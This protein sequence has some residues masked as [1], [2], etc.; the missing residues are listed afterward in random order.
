MF[1]LSVL[2]IVSLTIG[3]IC[4]IYLIRVKD[5]TFVS[6]DFIW[7]IGIYTGSSPFDLQGPDNVSN[8]VLTAKD[9]TD[10]RAGFV[11]DPFIVKEGGRWYMF[12]EVW[13]T[14][15][16]RAAIAYASS[17]DG[18]R[19]KYEQ[20][21]LKEPFHLSYPC[22]FKWKNEYYMIPE[23]L[24]NMNL[25]L[26]KA[27]QFP[28]KWEFV[29]V[30]VKGLYVDPTLFSHDN[31]LWLFAQTNPRGQD[32]LS[33]YFADDLFG[34]WQ[35]HPKSPV[36]VNDAHHARPAGRVFKWQ[37]RLFRVAQDDEVFYGKEVNAFEILELTPT[38]YREQKASAKPLV[39]ASGAGWNADGM[40]TVDAY[41]LDY[42]QWLAAVDGC[43]VKLK[44]KKRDILSL[45]FPFLAKRNS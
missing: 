10:L 45:I 28:V 27:V 20:A 38:F 13:D 17:E 44:C 26:Y 9:V 21:V 15:K 35:E 19:W 30:L 31:K 29:K 5:Y 14:W 32:Q 16:W 23:S 37:N 22:V 6:K 1:F 18:L 33:L 34:P 7:S 4:A 36:L 42:G 40:H 12:F 25:L 39:T 24:Q 2:I 11:A 8:P 3:F 41:Q 43:R